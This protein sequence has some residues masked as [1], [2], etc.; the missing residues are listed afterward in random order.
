[1][2]ELVASA[3]VAL[4][5]SACGPGSL[6][7]ELDDAVDPSE[8]DP[9]SEL[10][11]DGDEGDDARSPYGCKPRSGFSNGDKTRLT[12]LAV[13]TL[14]K[15]AGLACGP[16]LVTAVAV[17][18]AESGRFQYAFHINTGCSIDRGLWQINSYYHPKS[19]SYEAEANAKGMAT[20]SKQGTSFGPWWTF[21][22]GK[23][24]PFRASACAA[25]ESLCGEP[26][27]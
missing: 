23:H 18:A 13:A 3:L 24:E 9:W 27:C 2:R 22:K 12:Y 16:S 10:A 1:M 6:I 17:A 26:H 4:L 11:S 15:E 19:S 21:K 14:A 7:G 25:V 8:P 20:I 5:T